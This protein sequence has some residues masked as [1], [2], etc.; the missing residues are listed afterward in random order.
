MA[1]FNPEFFTNP[2][3]SLSTSFGIPT[4]MLNLGL[5]ALGLLDSSVL[6]SMAKAAKEGQ[7]AA[8]SAIAGVV[9]GLFSDMGILDYDAGTGKLSL[10]SDSSKFGIDLGFVDT[11]ASVTGALSEIENLIDQGDALA[12]ELKSCVQ[13]FEDWLKSTGPSQMTGT[14]GL[15]AGY[16]DAYTQ[17]ARIAALGL[18]RQ[19]IEEAV[20]FSNKCNDLLQN[21]GLILFERQQ[22][23]PAEDTEEDPIFRLV[24]GPPVSKNGLFILSEDGLYY[25]SQNRMY[26]G[27]PIPSASDVGFIV[28]SE[29]WKMDHASNLG[30]KG[31]IISADQLN[32]Y[33][34]TIFDINHIDDSKHLTTFYEEDHLLN[35][36]LGQKIKQVELVTTEINELLD[37]GYTEDSALVVNSRQSLNSVTDSF[38]QKINKRKKQIEVSVKAPDLFGSETSYSP[39]NVPVNDFSFLSSISLSVA[40]EKQESLVFAAGDVEDVVL[41][42]KPLFVT[43]Y[44]VTSRVT[45]D[46]LVVPPIGK[47]S[48][49]FSPSVS[50]TTA[51][52]ISLT[53]SIESAGLFSIYNFLKPDIVSPDS[54]DYKT[55]NCASPTTSG[56][57]QLVAKSAQSVFPSGVGIP[58]FGGLAR[59]KVNNYGLTVTNNYTKLPSTPDFQNLFYNQRG[60]SIDCWLHLPNYGTSAVSQ[61]IDP[62]NPF[63]PWTAGAWGDYNY[64][65]VLLANENTGGILPVPDVSSIYD[66]GGS[67][68]TKGLLIGFTRD[69][70]IY[71]DDFVIPGSGTLPGENIPGITTSGTCASSCFFIAPTMSFNQSSVEFVPDTNCAGDNQRYNKLVVRDDYTVGG[72][73]FTDVSAGFV[74]LHIS[75]DVSSDDCSVYLDGVK[76]TSSAMS[77]VLGNLPGQSA[78]IPTFIKPAD[79]AVSSFYYSTGSVTHNAGATTFNNGPNNDTYFTPWIVGGGWT[80]GLPI[81]STTKDGGFMGTRHGLTSGLNGLVGSLKFYSRPLDSSEVLKNYNAQKGFFKNIET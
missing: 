79:S 31:E 3:A 53:D 60:C 23:P 15:G 39:G 62:T 57:A 20:S 49:V 73:K 45:I 27:K 42:I 11:L 33:V 24:F 10:F 22:T 30:G 80:D 38:S 1:T 2:A 47:G 68:T 70:V 52:A 17:N 5:N 59:W 76:M 13:E 54:V 56:N 44:G 67:E 37:S 69:P 81:N 58:Y 40:L 41:P 26:N 12:A 9:N 71:H 14:G 6:N 43:N 64:Y 34:D 16:D 61:E 55:I 65:K 4:C 78:R 66:S 21:I 7:A 75:F 35:V 63:R 46:P 29:K 50:S 51:P 19:Q 18:A 8:R 25:D 74:H 77:K 72:K 32:K 36:L 48:V 28:D